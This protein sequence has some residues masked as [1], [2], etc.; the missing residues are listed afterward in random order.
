MLIQVKDINK[1]MDSTVI[2]VQNNARIENS[3]SERVIGLKF[4]I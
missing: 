2:Y 1:L 3:K 4:I